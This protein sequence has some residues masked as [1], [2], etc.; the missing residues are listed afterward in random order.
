MQDIWN[1][2]PKKY[3]YVAQDIT[4]RT[5][6]PVC[7]LDHLRVKMYFDSSLVSSS[8][9]R[10]MWKSHTCFCCKECRRK[11]RSTVSKLR[12]VRGFADRKLYNSS[13]SAQAPRPAKANIQLT[14][15]P[16]LVQKLWQRSTAVR[17]LCNSRS[18]VSISQN[19]KI[20]TS[21][22]RIDRK[23]WTTMKQWQ[24]VSFI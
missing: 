21:D 24:S 16:W 1:K 11:R 18:L 14:L 15:I 7:A 10:A 6:Q 23:A 13:R 5:A 17:S 8:M 3:S 9:W 19:C 2:N 12:M 20:R 4:C 22:Y